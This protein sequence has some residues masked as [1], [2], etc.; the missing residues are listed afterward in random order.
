MRDK[1]VGSYCTKQRGNEA[2]HR[3]IY[4]CYNSAVKAKNCDGQT[5]YSAMKIETAV[6]EIVDQYFK[7]I[8]Q[9]VDSVWR[10][11]ARIQLRSRQGVK[12]R[13][14]KAT[15]ERLERQQAEL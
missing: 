12:L 8:T 4:R 9:S 10:E 11:Q 7:S 14:A 3:P 15:L 6:L 13:A 1:L 5:V 2:Y